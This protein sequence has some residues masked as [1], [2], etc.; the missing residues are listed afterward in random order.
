MLSSILTTA[1]LLDILV[2]YLAKK[3][4]DGLF[5]SNPEEFQDRFMKVI[6]DTIAEY[7]SLY[8]IKDYLGKHAFYKSQR[9]V[10]ELLKYRL[11]NDKHNLS[12]LEKA[13]EEETNVIPPQKIEL[14]NFY[15]IFI[16]KINADETLRQLEISETFK[17]EIFEITKKLDNLSKSFDGVI[18]NIHNKLDSEWERQIYAYRDNIYKFKPK[19][20]LDLLIKLEES[21]E[22]SP[23]K[24]T[25]SLLATLE[26]LK[27]LCHELIGNHDEKHKCFIKSYRYNPEIIIFKEKACL[28][29]L[30]SGNNDEAQKII[31]EIL[32]IEEFN[33]VAWAVKVLV[34]KTNDLIKELDVVPKF[35]LEDADFKRIIYILTKSK[36][37]NKMLLEAYDK[38]FILP[39]SESFDKT[40]LTFK[41]YKSRI[42][43]IETLLS[44]ILQNL[45]LDFKITFTGD[46]KKVIALKPI[47]T[48]FFIQLA[49]SEIIDNY[50]E[51][52]FY[53]DYFEFILNGERDSIF[54]MKSSY[55]KIDNKEDSI[56]MIIAN[57]LQQA[58][59]VDEAIVIID[60]SESDNLELL[61]LKAFCFYKKNDIENYIKCSNEILNKT[62]IIDTISIEN[63]L[64]IAN[65]LNAIG[66]TDVIIIEKYVKD[67]EFEFDYLKVLIE[68]YLSVLLNTH[69]ETT[70]PKLQEIEKYLL[71]SKSSLL[72]NIAYTYFLL[73]E[74]DLAINLFRNYLNREIESRD[75]FI[76]IKSLDNAKIYNEELLE[77]LKYWRKYFSFNDELL[78]LEADLRRQLSDWAGCIEIC[79]YFLEKQ[80][81]EESFL[82][83]YLISINES[84]RTDKE[85]IIKEVA[86]ILSNIEFKFYTHVQIVSN[87]LLEN[88]YYELALNILYK[89]AIIKANKKA[90]TGF[91]YACT[92]VPYEIIKEKD[93]VSIGLFV[94][95]EL[96]HEI[97]F[98][99]IN[100]DDI[101]DKSL[102]GRK[103]G[104]IVT[105]QNPMFSNFDEIVI[106]R[107]MDKFLC[108]H[109]EILEEVRKNPYSGIP[110]QSVQFNDT[111]PQGLAQSLVSLMG[112]SGSLQKKQ[113]ENVF[114]QYYN[115]K[116]SFSEVIHQNY[117]S[118]YIGGY[119][120]LI[121]YRDG[122]TVVPSCYYPEVPKATIKNLVLDFSSLLLFHQLTME[123]ELKFEHKFILAKGILDYITA[124]KKKE[125]N[126][127]GERLFIN[128]SL[129][130]V[131]KSTKQEDTF[132]SNIQYLTKLIEWINENCIVKIVE[133]RLN[134]TRKYQGEI[135]DE[136]FANFLLDNIS[137]IMNEENCMLI[138]DDSINLKFY[139]IQSN[140]TISTE[141]YIN[142]YFGNSIPIM[143]ELIKNQYI[144]ITISKDIILI[145]YEK[146]MKGQINY[147]TNCINNLSLALN[148]NRQNIVTTIQ[149]LKEL[150]LKSLLIDDALKSEVINVF[151]IL[152]KGQS[153]W[154][155]FRLVEL[156]IN[157]EFELLGTK[158]DIMLECF[159]DAVRILNISKQ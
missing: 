136:P 11:M 127:T 158:L 55:E 72:F 33:P 148:P 107:I 3:G 131:S 115:Y 82:T 58:D 67:K 4:L 13:L 66:R 150:T 93:V 154:K 106:L 132:K 41:N 147:Y 25:N 73:H 46:I 98:K 38:Y 155:I 34:A 142:L 2:S 12:D 14:E 27:G 49:G 37:E 144:G 122:Y 92:K 137:L 65:I 91:F 114:L 151:I 60:E 86:N 94:K 20:A 85:K 83:L 149:F 87:I 145:E 29:F 129:D 22:M 153:E 17:E 36:Y 78:R 111:S 140:K 40:P 159:K 43:L 117:S 90:R 134:I 6:D 126:E 152:L 121:H 16:L 24:P 113:Q 42:F 125:L 133:S 116:L 128:I 120:D 50:K 35:T 80:K 26:F 139:P 156:L 63:I 138:S 95:Y 68:E 105:I 88:K 110:M 15:N 45:A 56:V 97:I 109:D 146:K 28:A 108:L 19:T 18:N 44:S 9:V 32:C 48:D 52:K 104:D 53:N 103:V 112:E 51:L 5:N 141:I 123:L 54:K 64:N 130:G 99:E 7:M 118:D 61:H 23:K 62:H 143:S 1:K 39:K 135:N 119:F 89:H 59:L 84:D 57:C 77:C 102:M 81:N 79:E 100:G 69:E 21:F 157:K 71:N 96:N 75:F 101:I 76:Y 70:I 47:L 74:Y 124:Y 31:K 8:P 10:D 30:L